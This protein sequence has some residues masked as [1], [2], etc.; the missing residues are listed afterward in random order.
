MASRVGVVD[1][2]NGLGAWSALAIGEQAFS[3]RGLSFVRALLFLWLFRGGEREERGLLT[4]FSDSL[5]L[6]KGRSCHNHLIDNSI[7]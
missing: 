3:S 2:V 7:M 5:P 1:C 4:G 6:C